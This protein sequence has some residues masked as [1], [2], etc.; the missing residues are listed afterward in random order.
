MKKNFFMLICGIFIISCNQVDEKTILE[1]DVYS[2]EWCIASEYNWSAN[3]IIKM[4]N[5]DLISYTINNKIIIDS[6]EI[7]LN[8]LTKCGNEFNSINCR[9]CCVINYSNKTK[10]TI[11]FNAPKLIKYK[12]VI[13]QP[14]PKLLDLILR[15][16]PAKNPYDCYFD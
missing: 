14:N 5:F 1:I 15:N 2:I 8:N 3:E 6:I 12:N 9:L 4:K 13:N 10:D 16:H 7:E 11:S